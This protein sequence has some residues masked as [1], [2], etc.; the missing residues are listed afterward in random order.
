MSWWCYCCWT[1]CLTQRAT[2]LQFWKCLHLFKDTPPT[3]YFILTSLF[4]SLMYLFLNI[5]FINVYLG[6]TLLSPQKAS[7]MPSA[8]H[9]FYLVD[10]IYLVLD[11][12]EEREKEKRERDIN[13]WLP[14]QCPPL[15]TWPATQACAPTRS[16][17]G[18]PLVRSLVLNPVSRTSRGCFL[19]S[20]KA[21]VKNRNPDW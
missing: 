19:C 14:L 17:T 15:E 2:F 12:G 9:V 6:P 20:G 10:F 5:N 1:W 11:R 3:M 16:R 18:D 13:V 21:Q 7:R 8:L 4:S